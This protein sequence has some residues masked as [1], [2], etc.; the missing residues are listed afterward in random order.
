MPFFIIGIAI[1]IGSILI[2]IAMQFPWTLA[3]IG[4]VFGA[5]VTAGF[6]W[7]ASSLE[8][9]IPLG[10][11]LII[12]KFAKLLGPLGPIIAG[13]VAIVVGLIMFLVMGL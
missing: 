2:N 6:E 9:I 11:F 8:I 7:I 5:D 3:L 1:I 10:I 4:G 13:A 12:W